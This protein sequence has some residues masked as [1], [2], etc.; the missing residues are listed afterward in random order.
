LPSPLWLSPSTQSRARASLSV[1]TTS[2]RAGRSVRAEIPVLL[3]VSSLGSGRTA[4]RRSQPRPKRQRRRPRRGKPTAVVPERAAS[5]PLC[6]GSRRLRKG[7]KSRS[8]PRRT[9]PRARTRRP[10]RTSVYSRTVWC[11]TNR[12]GRGELGLTNCHRFRRRC[13]PLSR[14]TRIETRSD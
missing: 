5:K 2:S 11:V 4:D 10:R 14:W 13:S 8:R 1:W 3:S 12:D 6:S 7:I 9:R